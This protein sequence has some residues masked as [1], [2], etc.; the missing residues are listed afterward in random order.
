[1]RDPERISRILALLAEK[2]NAAPDL[3][4]GQLVSHITHQF[5][6]PL[7]S[8]EDDEIELVL[9]GYKPNF[10]TMKFEKDGDEPICMKELH[11]KHVA[12]FSEAC[13]GMLDAITDKYRRKE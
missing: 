1:M 9:R 13:K 11:E 10:V 8:V 12:A 6:T 5:G 4:F 2:W 3:R 7:F